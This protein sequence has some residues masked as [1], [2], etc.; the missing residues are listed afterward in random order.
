MHQKYLVYWVRVS[1][2]NEVP[3]E[4]QQRPELRYSDG[5]D[6][7][8]IARIALDIRSS[9]QNLPKKHINIKES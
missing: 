4:M 1:S 9:L 6:I 5:L 8:E 2:T 3:K 7:S